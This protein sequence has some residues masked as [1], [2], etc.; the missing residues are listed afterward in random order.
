MR[1]SQFSVFLLFFTS[2]YFLEVEKLVAATCEKN[3]ANIVQVKGKVD[4]PKNSSYSKK[5]QEVLNDALSQAF[6]A[7]NPTESSSLTKFSTSASSSANGST[8]AQREVS[9]VSVAFKQIKTRK[10]I[11]LGEFKITDQMGFKF[12]ERE[13]EIEVCKI[14]EKNNIYRVSINSVLWSKRPVRRFQ[15]TVIAAFPKSKRISVFLASRGKELANVNIRGVV[16]RAASRRNGNYYDIVVRVALSA[17]LNQHHRQ[18]S[19]YHK[20]QKKVSISE[21]D[22]RSVRAALDE[23]FEKV[24]IKLGKRLIEVML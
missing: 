9:E 17:H 22:I 18:I 7:T 5:K 1:I 3:E 20:I 10:I 6:L 14:N 11:P 24:S 15:S 8:V 12:L 19:E 4:F 2:F 13:F 23:A 21:G 16:D